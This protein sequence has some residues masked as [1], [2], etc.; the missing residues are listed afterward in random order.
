MKYGVVE[1]ST[2]STVLMLYIE[3][4]LMLYPH[5][6]H[7]FTEIR[8]AGGRWGGGKGGGHNEERKREILIECL[9]FAELGIDKIC[10]KH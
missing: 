10:I 9:P 5:S 2:I 1:R 8:V 6:M 3:E 7:K 4:I